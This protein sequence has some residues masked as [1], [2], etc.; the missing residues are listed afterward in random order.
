MTTNTQPQAEPFGPEI[1]CA[2]AIYHLAGSTLS[3]AN[4]GANVNRTFVQ[5]VAAMMLSRATTTLCAVE[6]LFCGGFE[7]EAAIVGRTIV[8]LRIDLAWILSDDTEVRARRY[9]ESFDHTINRMTSS[10]IAVGQAIPTDDA[11]APHAMPAVAEMA[12]IQGT[13]NREL[14][15]EYKVQDW[16]P[17][18]LYDRAKAVGLEQVYRVDYAYGSSAAHSCG[19]SVMAGITDVGGGSMMMRVGPAIPETRLPLKLALFN[20]LS[21]FHMAAPHIGIAVAPIE[22]AMRHAQAV[23]GPERA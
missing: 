8:E 21:L 22:Q 7:R 18:K 10:L 2:R 4:I 23:F 6:Y 1:M 16:T 15:A 19:F 3:A 17:M 13:L 11:R 14:L 9:R 5:D 20:F 12:Q